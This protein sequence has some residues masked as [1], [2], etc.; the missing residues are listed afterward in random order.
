MNFPMPTD[1]ELH[2]AF[3]Q[4]EAA[5]MAVFPAV[6]TPVGALAQQL[7][8]QGAG[9]Q[10]GE[11]RLAKSSHNSRK[12][13]ARDGYGKRKRDANLRPRR[14]KLGRRTSPTT[15]IFPWSG[16]RRY[17]KTWYSTG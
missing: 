4:G 6:A 2:T 8:Q 1:E 9:V 7:A 14:C 5:V 11:D 17:V 12:P 16:R 3:E 15:T 13:P 10:E